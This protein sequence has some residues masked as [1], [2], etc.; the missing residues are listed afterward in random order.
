MLTNPQF[1]TMKNKYVTSI[2]NLSPPSATSDLL[3]PDG[4]M[5][6]PRW[7]FS[8][9]EVEGLKKNSGNTSSGNISDNN[10]SQ[11]TS[12]RTIPYKENIPLFRLHPGQ[13]L[14]M[15]HTPS[16]KNQPHALVAT[17]DSRVAVL[18]P[19]SDILHMISPSNSPAIKEAAQTDSFISF[20]TDKGLHY[21]YYRADTDSYT[22]MGPSPEAP[23]VTF[24]MKPVPMPPYSHTE[25][26]FPIMEV[27][28]PVADNHS[29]ACIDWLAGHN[30]SLCPDSVKICVRKA[31]AASFQEFIS[32]AGNAGLDYFPVMAK[33]AYMAEDRSLFRPAEPQLL[34]PEES[35]VLRIVA[36]SHVSG[37]LHLR[38]TAGRRPFRITATPLITLTAPWRKVLPQLALM[39]TAS[40]ADILLAADVGDA[41]STG[42]GTRGF[43]PAMT[44]SSAL[45]T[46]AAT[47]H[48][49]HI[50]A[51]PS[52]TIHSSDEPLPPLHEE[53]KP[54]IMPAGPHSHSPRHICSHCGTL[55]SLGAHLGIYRTG[56]PMLESGMCRLADS[57]PLT[58]APSLKPLS[59]GQFGEFPLYA[60][61]TDGIHALA[62]DE[63]GGFRNVQLISRHT[64]LSAESTTLLPDATAF[65]S[66]QGV[67]KVSGTTVT[68]LSE[69]LDASDLYWQF[70]SDDRLAYHYRSDSLILYRPGLP[71]CRLY[72]MASG[73]WRR[74]TMP[75]TRLLESSTALY[76]LNDDGYIHTIGSTREEIDAPADTPPAS[77]PDDNPQCPGT[78]SPEIPPL[79]VADN[80]LAYTRP[81]KFGNPFLETRLRR[82]SIMWPDGKQRPYRLESADIAG[83]WRKIASSDGRSIQLR[84]S[85]HRLYRFA[86]WFPL[87]PDA[88]N[89]NYFPNIKP[90]IYCLLKK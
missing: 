52:T 42:N 90:L 22:W 67:A 26:D 37:I 64:P 45:D 30:T 75:G 86:L 15:L 55:F 69:K 66:R 79:I 77:N 72:N 19:G 53:S 71:E 78:P 48:R 17:S 27:S 2:F 82:I 35:P 16:E 24:A 80:F 58:V 25:A 87:P 83:K 70:S 39:R 32:A 68:I 20:L 49:F 89:L 41:V 12:F 29:Q 5:I 21:A 44:D 56:Y 88:K 33:A 43:R 46:L 81:F 40:H 8:K 38:L 34:Q 84:G 18:K 73:E 61:A 51:T 57:I 28:A 13:R 59:S 3:C 23:A 63:T 65:V 47:D 7:I 62:P 54:A 10:T 6:S 31:V 76:S 36:V 4:E 85:G 11:T 14:I 9:E 50:T 60:F 1:C 74:W